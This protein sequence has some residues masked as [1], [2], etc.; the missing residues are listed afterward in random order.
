MNFNNLQ[1]YYTYLNED[2]FFKENIGLS[3]HL[4]PLQHK[5]I[6]EEEK[7]NCVL[8]ISFNDFN[9]KNGIYV[10]LFSAGSNCYPDLNAFDDLDYLKQRA[11]ETVN[12]KYKAKYY[13]LLY[14]KTKDK[15]EAIKAIESYLEFLRNSNLGLKDNSEIRG[16]IDA[17]DNLIHLVDKVKYDKI[18]DV[19]QF[20]KD[21]IQGNKVNGF[22]LYNIMDFV[23]N[24]MKLASDTKQFFYDIIE[25][26]IN[27]IQYPEHRED[28][29]KLIIDLAQKIGKPQQEFQNLLGDFYLDKAD[30]EGKGFYVQNIYLKALN[31]YIK[32]GNKAKQDEVSKLMQ[33][34]KNSI[35]L[36]KVETKLAHPLIDKFFKSLDEIT[37]ELTENYSS[38]TVYQ[39]LILEK[40]IFP[41][42]S[43]LDEFTKPQTLDFITTIT[44]DKNKNIDVNNSQGFNSY[45]MSFQLCSLEH[46]KQV[47]FKGQA[48]GKITFESLKDY[49]ENN[50]WYKD[51]NIIIN[52]DGSDY[53]FKWIDFILPPLKLFFE[54]SENDNDNKCHTPEGYIFVIDSLTLKFEG[55]LRDFS[56]KIG[57]QTIESENTKTK[58]RIDF[59][60]MFN[61]EKFKSA[62]PEDDIAFFKF[63]FTRKGL[64]I[65]NN[66]A[67]SFYS[68]KDYS[69]S[70]VW[71][72]ICAYLKLGNFEFKVN[73]KNGEKL[74]L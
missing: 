13:H 15:R 46:L 54:Q 11:L 8:E 25:A 17:F 49:I 14:H 53:S 28:F 69:I 35:K 63:L 7:K 21:L 52:P 66:V 59:D 48:N 5:L 31:I 45:Q 22:C 51:V 61:N 42:A 72:L 10:P 71:L 2:N 38:D 12:Y 56:N 74:Y 4:K 37:T 68:P 33:D 9:F 27:A 67:H 41:K 55:V 16:F 24:N 47:F 20:V 58:Q 26:E 40:K 3:S 30:K 44:F 39:Y 43:T 34:S 64:D 50:T 19:I 65:R 23:I 32:S 6:S 18:D 60:K 1:E 29:L 57:A 62:I 73:K 70:M 36:S